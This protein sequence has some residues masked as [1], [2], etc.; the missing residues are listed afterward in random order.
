MAG[1]LTDQLR[2]VTRAQSDLHPV[3]S[4]DVGDGT[5]G[6][7]GSTPRKPFGW[8]ALVAL[9]VLV[10]GGWLVVRQ[11]QADSNLQDCV[12]SGRKNCAP[13][14]TGSGPP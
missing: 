12:M 13:I 6:T 14:D 3:K 2:K 4:E 1:R 7:G 11:L 5:S 10:V 9:V 8:F